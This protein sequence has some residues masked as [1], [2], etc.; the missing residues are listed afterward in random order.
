MLRTVQAVFQLMPRSLPQS[1]NRIRDNYLEKSP[2]VKPIH[3][4]RQ[5]GQPQP[6]RGA[7]LD[8]STHK[9]N[10]Q[11]DTTIR[12]GFGDSGAGGAMFL[13]QSYIALCDFLIE[14]TSKLQVRFELIHVGDVTNAPYGEKSHEAIA[15]LTKGFVGFLGDKGAQFA[16]IA[17]NTAS[18]TFDDQMNAALKKRFPDMETL[19]IIEL[20]PIV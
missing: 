1:V 19:P 9:N 14:Q 16:V 4:F 7:S 10:E 15:K 8:R 18:T 12:I 11:K 17:C 2:T 5:P 6:F 13:I 3:N 20:V